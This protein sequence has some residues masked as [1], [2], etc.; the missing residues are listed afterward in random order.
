MPTYNF[1]NKKTKKR[2]T[3]V[4][5]MTEVEKYVADNPEVEWLCSAAPMGD[6]WRMG[7][8]KPDG[9]FRDRLKEIKKS[10]RGSDI[11]TWN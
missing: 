3:K 1:I 6:P 7:R 5:S 11:N 2:F 9:E 8:V 10:H 4:L